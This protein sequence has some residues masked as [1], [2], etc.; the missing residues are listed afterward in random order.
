MGGFF[1]SFWRVFESEVSPYSTGCVE[2]VSAGNLSRGASNT[3]DRDALFSSEKTKFD[4]F[5]DC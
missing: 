4:S 3:L 5:L 1:L 2:E